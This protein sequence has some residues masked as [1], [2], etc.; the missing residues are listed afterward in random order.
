MRGWLHRSR[1]T[2]LNQAFL[3]VAVAQATHPSAYWRFIE[4]LGYMERWLGRC[5]PLPEP[6]DLA[7][8]L[9]VD[10]KPGEGAVVQLQAHAKRRA[11]RRMSEPTRRESNA[12]ANA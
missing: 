5:A 7:R 4:G 3:H 6:M 11:K 1:H 12:V 9:G 8:Q 10:A 2:T